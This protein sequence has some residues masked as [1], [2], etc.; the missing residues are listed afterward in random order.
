VVADESP[1]LGE[2]TNIPELAELRVAD[3]AA[4]WEALGFA[5]P[6]DDME[7]GGVRVTLGVAG[8]GI[9]GWAIRGIDATTGVDGLP[10]AIDGLPTAPAGTPSQPNPVPHPNGASG[11][12]HV[13]VVTPDFDRTAAALAETGMPLRRVREVGTPGEPAAFR[14]GFR[15]LGPAILELVEAKTAPPG[16]ATFWGL[17][18]IVEDLSALASRLGD[19]LASIKPAVQP[20][21]HIATLRESAGLT[22]KVAF[23]DPEAR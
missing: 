23:M 20:G 9:T 6:G 15:R 16:P 22:P 1:V 2:E 3:P 19:H 5:V 13:V 17:V 10:T 11:I 7:L 12:D 21:R 4:R 18:V 14:Q 8:Q